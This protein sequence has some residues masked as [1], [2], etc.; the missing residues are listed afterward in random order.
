MAP[1][2]NRPQKN[3]I[4]YFSNNTAMELGV[5]EWCG[6]KKMQRRMGWFIFLFSKQ[7]IENTYC[8]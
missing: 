6:L 8:C 7:V 4:N 2:N 3:D 1:N 5:R